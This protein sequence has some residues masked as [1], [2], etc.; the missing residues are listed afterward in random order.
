VICQFRE[1]GAA[2]QKLAPPIDRFLIAEG[3]SASQKCWVTGPNLRETL[4][5]V[6]HPYRQH[7]GFAGSETF[8]DDAPLIAGLF[9]FQWIMEPLLD[10]S[11]AS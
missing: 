5:S 2:R 6:L 10:G 7:Y 8:F 1:Y 9:A 11:G 3:I 4:A